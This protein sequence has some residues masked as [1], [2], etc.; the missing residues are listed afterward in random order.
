MTAFVRKL[1]L[2]AMTAPLA[3]CVLCADRT[4]S[5]HAQNAQDTQKSGAITVKG[6]LAYRERI[7]LIPNSTARI[8]VSDISIADRKAPVIAEQEMELG[9]QQ[10]PIKFSLEI[11][12]ARLQPRRRYSLRATISDPAGQLI[13]TTD[14]ARIVDP[15]Q[16]VNDLGTL[17]LVRVNQQT[18]ATP[19]TITGVEWVVENIADGGIIDASRA[20][21]NFDAGGRLYGRASCNNYS[22]E[23]SARGNKLQVGNLAVTQRACVPALGNQE[24]EF[25]RV[26]Q[27]AESFSFDANGKLILRS[28]SGETL[29][30][31]PGK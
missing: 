8:T 20:T 28:D 25:L 4:T 6:A 21:L 2:L 12:K 31:Y 5:A 3:A 19:S 22:G 27:N 15:Q 14:T 24:Q 26:L 9:R 1:L 30:A 11:E 17:R 29:E 13:W 16:A 18:S 7:A 23:Y 10:V